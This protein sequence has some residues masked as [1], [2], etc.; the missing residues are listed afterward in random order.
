[1]KKIAVI[2]YGFPG[3]GKGT[4]ANLLAQKYNLVHFDTGKALE[5]A[6]HDP[7]RQKNKEIAHE[8]EL[9]DSGSL[10]TPSFVA[11]EV[12]RQI[13]HIASTGMGLVLSG[14][15]RTLPEAETLVPIME[16][17][18]G[19]Q[20]L[21]VFYISIT[22]DESIKRNSARKICTVCGNPFLSAYY[23]SQTSNHCAVCAAPLYKRTLDNP[24]VIKVRQKQ[25]LDRTKPILNFLKKRKYKVQS[26]NGKPAPYV[27]FK[28][29]YGYLEK[30]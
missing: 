30:R 25:F 17:L 7:K 15:P 19:K 1:M 2:F 26:I 16:D 20:N 11:K 24:E 5:S 14:S 29:I 27:I 4:Q 22:A 18:Y 8:R 9:F 10:M 21:H 28:K 13:R 3:S 12:E 23:P 6:V